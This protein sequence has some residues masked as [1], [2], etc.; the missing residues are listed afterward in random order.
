MGRGRVALYSRDERYASAFAE[1]CG[2]YERERLTVKAYTN[3]QSLYGC[4]IKK[5]VDILLTDDISVLA[6][7]EDVDIRYVIL[8]EN[9][10]TSD[11][12]KTCIY[13][14]Q[15]M[16]CIIK[17]LYQVLAEHIPEGEYNCSIQLSGPDIIGCFSPCY[18]EVREQYS[19]ALAECKAKEGRT[20]FINFAMFTSY[21]AEGE[22]GLSELLY[23]ASRE[24]NAIVYRLPVFVKNISGYES[25]PGV[26]NYVDLYDLDCE[27]V[28]SLFKLLMT[29]NEYKTIIVDLGIEGDIG[30]AVLSHCSEIFMPV[31]AEMDNRRIRHLKRD[32]SDGSG[33]E[34][35]SR[36]KEIKLPGWW[37]SSPE[38]RMRWVSDTYGL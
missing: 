19:R 27:V 1:Y 24:E 7:M 38:R 8:S 37:N 34:Y 15:R 20:L 22:E 5:Q 25:V 10:Y 13:K 16:D 26:R 14:F 17:Q 3:A 28:H 6:D 29:M 35:M 36:T 11:K 21:D 30:D 12:D 33:E 31:P 9:K 18:E 23:Y 32:Y 4:L 2:K